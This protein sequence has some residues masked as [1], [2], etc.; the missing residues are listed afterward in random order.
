[1]AFF[2]KLDEATSDSPIMGI[3]ASTL[4]NPESPRSSKFAPLDPPPQINRVTLAQRKQEVV[5]IRNSTHERKRR[6]I[7]ERREEQARLA[8]ENL[9]RR[10]DGAC[11]R[12]AAKLSKQ[13]ARL[14]EHHRRVELLR[15]PKSTPL[16]TPLSSPPGSP[17]TSDS[18]YSSMFSSS[19][20]KSPYL[21]GS[22]VFPPSFSLAS[23]PNSG[24]PSFPTKASPRRVSERLKRAS[25]R[26]LALSLER[27]RQSTAALERSEMAA[28]RREE[29]I[30]RRRK[31]AGGK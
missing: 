26:R 24:S 20:E 5:A 11:L 23:P 28:I 1:M 17:I 9:H 10:V 22:R 16:F 13:K 7:R 8:E 27:S 4:F 19:P 6:V 30:E 29:K 18:G 31:E 15:S 3:P 21:P 14:E 12:R 25:R 2:L